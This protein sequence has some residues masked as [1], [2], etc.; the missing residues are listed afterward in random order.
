MDVEIGNNIWEYINLIFGTVYLTPDIR[1]WG[2]GWVGIGWVWQSLPLP[3]FCSLYIWLAFS[4]LP[5]S[6]AQHLFRR[7]H[8]RGGRGPALYL[9]DQRMVGRSLSGM[10]RGGLGR[11]IYLE[12]TVN[13]GDTSWNDHIKIGCWR[14]RTLARMI[15][16]LWRKG[17]RME[18][19][20]E[21]REKGQWEVASPRM[22]RGL[23]RK[24]SHL[25]WP[26][27]KGFLRKYLYLECAEYGG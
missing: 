20:K 18:W 4:L 7:Y 17:L 14:K 22:T 24:W 10:T 21:G 25:G 23:W 19:Q 2:I 6:C 15:S 8:K 5:L 3:S 9:D 27:T 11:G 1:K 13:D 12:C 16:G 26:L